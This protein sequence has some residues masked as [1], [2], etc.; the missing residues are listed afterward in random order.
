[1]NAENEKAGNSTPTF[2]S[3]GLLFL[4][5]GQPSLLGGIWPTAQTLALSLV[6]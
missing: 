5:P 4:L 2:L 3:K 1:M 6:P